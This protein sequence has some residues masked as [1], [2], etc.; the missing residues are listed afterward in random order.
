MGAQQR[1]FKAKISSTSSLRKIF[2]AMELIAASRIQ[3]AI[4]RVKG[5]TPYA[6]ALTR[7]V[8]AVATLSNVDHVLTTERE[9]V[10]SAAVVVMGPDRGFAGAY[11]SNVIK[12]AEELVELL[13]AEGKQVKLYT[14]GRKP[15]TYYTFR[16]R[17]IERSWTGIS[18]TPTYEDAR[19]I[20]QTLLGS[21]EA[22]SAGGGVDELYLV[23]TRFKSSV[24]YDPEYL[25]LL[26]LEV[27]DA[28]EAPGNQAPAAGGEVFPLYEFEP[29][30]EAVLDALLPKYIES[31]ILAAL[32]NASASEQAARQQAMN[33]AV[34]NADELIKTYTRLAN[35]ARQAE[36]TA[37]ISEIVGGADALASSGVAD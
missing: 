33:T 26:P 24:A 8:S 17:A 31:R 32:L 1:V 15:E 13:Q 10:R 19:E 29:S 3:K 6:Q 22:G 16:D 27:V 34:D 12:Q 7:A 21:F 20:G 23:F 4:A 9:D 11:S 5:S 2:K 35:N 30:S 37:E 28:P 25:R 14:V 36:I 18:E